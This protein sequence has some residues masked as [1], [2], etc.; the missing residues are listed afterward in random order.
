LPSP[1]FLNSTAEGDA[2]MRLDVSRCVK[3]RA[4]VAAA[5][6]APELP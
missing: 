3:A 6:H 2:L 4:R 1:Q 5:G